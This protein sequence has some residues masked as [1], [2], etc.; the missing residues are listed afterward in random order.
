MVTR[1]S[2]VATAAGSEPLLQRK[3]AYMQFSCRNMHIS[4]THLLFFP[5]LVQG[6]LCSKPVAPT[7][8][9]ASRWI[10]QADTAVYFKVTV[11]RPG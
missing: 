7:S 1:A 10:K 3:A 9:S 4:H 5:L 11:D 2:L 6:L 8:A